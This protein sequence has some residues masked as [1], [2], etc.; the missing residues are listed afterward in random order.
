MSSRNIALVVL[1]LL[2]TIGTAKA[3][4]YDYVSAD[5]DYCSNNIGSSAD[6]CNTWSDISPA[7]GTFGVSVYAVCSDEDY[8]GLF[9]TWEG[10]ASASVYEGCG[11][12]I[13]SVTGWAPDDTDQ[14]VDPDYD[15]IYI[16]SEGIIA[17]AFYNEDE[18]FGSASAYS[19]FEADCF[20]QT[21]VNEV[22]SPEEC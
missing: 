12:G 15:Y 2:G 3:Q 14:Y 10:G 4:F 13:V 20:G 8:L 19:I 21:I 6:P 9:G 7:L 11:N 16:E 22:S 18:E 17:Q 1:C 5:L